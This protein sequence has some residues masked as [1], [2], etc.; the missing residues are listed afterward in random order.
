MPINNTAMKYV[1]LI[2]LYKILSVSN[3]S[4]KKQGCTDCNATNYNTEAK[5]D[6]NSCLFVNEDLWGTYAVKDSI[7]GPPTLE[8]YHSSYDLDISRSLCAPNNLTFSNYANNNYNF[9]G[10]TFS[11]DCQINNRKKLP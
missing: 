5:K 1:Q 4:C 3:L 2:L 7:T 9:N 10:T 11:I 6:D 8:W